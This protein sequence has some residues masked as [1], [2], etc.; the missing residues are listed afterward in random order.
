MMDFAIAW[1]KVQIGQRVRVSNGLPE[2]SK[3]DGRPHAIWRSHNHEGEVV[4][5][6]DGAFRAIR[7][8]LDEHEGAQ[9]AYDVSEMSGDKFELL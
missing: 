2:P 6:I 4:E 7:V 1:K 3:P 5:K 8:Q 9:V